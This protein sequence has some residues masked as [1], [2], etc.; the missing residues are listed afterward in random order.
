MGTGGGQA[1]WSCRP[2]QKSQAGVVL[3]QKAVTSC[4]WL[5]GH[6]LPC[7]ML[8]KHLST[9]VWEEGICLQTGWQCWPYCELSLVAGSTVR[10]GC[11]PPLAMK[12]WPDKHLA[13]S[14]YLLALVICIVFVV[15]SW[16]A[17]LQ[18]DLK[19]LAE[20]WW[21]KGPPLQGS[22]RVCRDGVYSQ[23]IQDGYSLALWTSP[24]WPV[25]TLPA[26]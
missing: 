19:D 9:Q 25:P 13:S 2:R 26:H 24:P 5:N 6:D 15:F 11:C 22:C 8:I 18:T 14:C 10:C 23:A 4:I 1:V 16:T 12:N 3:S 21:T 20:E 17:S 7:N